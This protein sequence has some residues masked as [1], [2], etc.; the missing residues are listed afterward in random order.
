MPG[1]PVTHTGPAGE[2]AAHPVPNMS[3]PIVPPNVSAHPPS[4]VNATR[5]TAVTLM[6]Q[7]I[8][9][10]LQVASLVALAHILRPADFGLVAMVTAILGIAEILRDFGLSSAAIQARHLSDDERTNLFW[11]N[12]GIG[13]LCSVAAAS[14]SGL[15]AHMY[16]RS[17]LVAVSLSLSW[18][19][20]VSGA[21][22]Q[23]RAELARSLRFTNLAITD[24]AAQFAAVTVAVGSALLGLSYWSIVLQQTVFVITTCTLNVAMCTWRP[25]RPKR[26]VSLR[27]FFRYGGGLLGMQ[28]LGYGT[29]N[30]DTITLG[31]V[32]GPGPVGLYSRG[33]QLLMV[34]LSQI[35]AAMVRVMLPVMSRAQDDEVA[36]GRLIR[37]AQVLCGY[38]FGLGYSVAAGL[39]APTVLL[40]FGSSWRGVTPIFAILAV[41]GVFRGLAQTTYWICLAKG[42]TGSQLRFYLIARPF[43]ILAIVAGLPW[44]PVGVAVGHSIAFM[45]E[46]VAA[47]WWVARA[48]DMDWRPLLRIPLRMVVVVCLPAGSLAFVS[49]LIS[50]APIASIAIGAGAVLGYILLLRLISP[51]ERGDLN[52]VAAAVRRVG[53]RAGRP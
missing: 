25:T 10:V 35:G 12:L 52:T 6:A 11:A 40:L 46:W 27:R 48:A 13:A 14:C 3:E 34:P 24:I 32:W 16:G 18:L 23:F 15:I 41:G 9:L 30:V 50:A 21:N 36:F 37:R 29:N 44:G 31:A 8:R 49:T 28:V 42:V 7:G 2:E 26:H 5:G 33:Y 20:L 1:R 19:F 47:A 4:P 53:A 43:M 39:A 45:V 51:I 38:G 22:T 17:D